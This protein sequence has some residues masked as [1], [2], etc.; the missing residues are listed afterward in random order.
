MK[1]QL[2]IVFSVGLA[3][4]FLTALLIKRI[5]TKPQ[6]EDLAPE[7]MPYYTK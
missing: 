6:P 2:I 3:V 5:A 7:T 1:K 4:G